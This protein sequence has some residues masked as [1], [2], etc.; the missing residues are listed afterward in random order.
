MDRSKEWTRN[1]AE[2]DAWEPASGGQEAGKNQRK[3]KDAHDEVAHTSVGVHDMR[4]S[5]YR[6]CGS[7]HKS[8]FW[9]QRTSSLPHEKSLGSRRTWSTRALYGNP[10]PASA[11]TIN[12]GW[13]S[14]V[15]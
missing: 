11:Q 7:V 5:K 8:P 14:G 12:P 13:G 1:K 15:G 4:D 2:S 6:V 3:R 10:S 9:F